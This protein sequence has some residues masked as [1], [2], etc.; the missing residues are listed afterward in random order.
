M[1][2]YHPIQAWS[3][4][5]KRKPDGKRIISFQGPTQGDKADKWEGIQLPCGQCIGCRLDYSRQWADRILLE[6]TLWE[7]NWFV[8]LTYSDEFVPYKSTVNTTTGELIEGKTLV[9]E[10]L[11]KFMKD[12]RRYWSYHYGHDNIRFYACGEY[13]GQTER[14]HYHLCI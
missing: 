9:P 7:H 11:T 13:G 1:P 4:K 6:T 5:D 8:T 12:L 3:L 10:H 2:C 14:P